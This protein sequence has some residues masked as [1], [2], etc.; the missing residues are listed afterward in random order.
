[1]VALL[2]NFRHPLETLRGPEFLVVYAVWF[3]VCW[4]GLLFLRSC[5]LD[6]PLTTI[7]ALALFEALG[8]ARFLIGS[9]MGLHRWTFLFLMMGIG[10]LFFLTRARRADGGT[11]DTSSATSSFV[12]SSVGGGG[13]GGGGCGGGGCGGCGGS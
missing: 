8:L 4:S 6:R 11:R 9:A 12:D 2:S 10:A 1:M 3:F 5:G 7:L 13:C